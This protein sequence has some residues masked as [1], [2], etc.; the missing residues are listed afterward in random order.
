[1]TAIASA[2]DRP[3]AL[4]G[5]GAGG[6]AGD[7]VR[8]AG[9][10]VDALAEV[11]Q[12][13]LG[14]DPARTV[15]LVDLLD[16]PVEAPV[17]V[18]RAGDDLLP[19]LAHEGALGDTLCLA[20]RALRPGGLF[21][22]AVPELDGLR[23]LRPTAPPPR[24]LGHGERRQVTVQLWDWSDDGSCYGLEVVQLVR[25]AGAW[26]IARTVS[27]RHRVLTQ[28]EVASALA[29]AG[30]AAVQRLAPAESGHPL[31]VWVAVAP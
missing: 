10:T 26:E 6:G 25:R 5:G 20:R 14:G 17:D 3:S 13:V 16:G 24:V 21:V 4:D 31:P 7:D 27:T 9:E 11:A 1:M 28:E 18:V 12:C 15:D 22:A 2:L 8:P 19:R 23:R 29:D 30:F